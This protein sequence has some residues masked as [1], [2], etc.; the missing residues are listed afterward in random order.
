MSS[1]PSALSSRQLAIGAALVSCSLASTDAFASVGSLQHTTVNS[2]TGTM[3]AGS[4]SFTYTL[5]VPPSTGFTYVNNA[6]GISRAAAGIAYSGFDTIILALVTGSS[7]Y[8][9]ASGSG[10]VSL[11]FSVD[12]TFTDLVFPATGVSCGWKYGGVFVNNGDVFLASGSPY[13][14]TID[15]TYSGAAHNNFLSYG[16][17]S[18]AAPAIPLPGAAGL[19]ACGLLGLARRRRR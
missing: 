5:P 12:V 6:G 10:T 11:T 7:Y 2:F 14:F 17:F 3:T 15:Y 1:A 8:T 16:G 13:L 4:N 18:P 19:A 9:S